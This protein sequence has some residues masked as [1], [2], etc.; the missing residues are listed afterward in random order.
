MKKLIIGFIGVDQPGIVGRL[1]HLVNSH[2]GS[3]QE[4]QMVQLDGY[5]SGIASVDIDPTANDALK[6]ELSAIDG[7][8]VNLLDSLGRGD[9]GGQPVTLNI[10][11]PDRTGI[12]AEVS[13]AMASRNINV[14][15]MVTRVE[16]ASMSGELLFHAD[17]DV[18]LP[19]DTDLASLAA[20]LDEIGNRLGVD[21]LIEDAPEG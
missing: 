21:V 9:R 19:G 2:G 13:G 1:S 18:S 11:G 4:S 6:A 5:F 10:I 3:W 8:T 12:L 16:P 15:N 17:A 7:L 20:E 14:T